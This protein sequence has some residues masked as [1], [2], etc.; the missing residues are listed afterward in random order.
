MYVILGGGIAGLSAGFHLA[1]KNKPSVIFEQNPSWGGLCDNFSID[2]FRFDYCIHYSITR[3]KYVKKLFAASTDCYTYVPKPYNYY[4][5]HWIKHPVQNN[6]YP[7]PTEEKQ[8]IINS[9]LSREIT[10]KKAINNYEEWLF[11]QYGEYFARKFP[12]RY[13]LKYWT[14]PAGMLS[15]LWIRNRISSIN[16]AALRYGCR[17]PHTTH[18]YYASEIRYP[19]KAGY[20]SFLNHMVPGCTIQLN[21]KVVEID[22]KIRK[23]FFSDGSHTHYDYLISSLPLPELILMIKDVPVSVKSAADKLLATSVHLVSLGFNRPDIPPFQWFYIY[24][25]EILPARAYSPGHKSPDNVPHECSSLQFEIYS[26]KKNP[27]NCT[28]DNLI[29]HVVTKGQK[30]GLFEARDIIVSDYRK[31]PYGNVV[32]EKNMYRQRDEVHHYL[33]QCR[34]RYIGRFGEWDYLWSD[35]SLLSGKKVSEI[36]D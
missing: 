19:K 2:G 15:T 16:L 26:S 17:V 18:N 12:M 3:N 22:P 14:V 20:K 4:N 7:L 33:D 21:K 5:R 29:E 9:F 10:S 13:T 35:Q 25:E 24:D 11:F 23:I 30:M 8:E 28:P 27:L 31:V 34:I 36:E 32:F 6:L 1:Q